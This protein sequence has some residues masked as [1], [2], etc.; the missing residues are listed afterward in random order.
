MVTGASTAELAIVLVDA[1]KGVARADP[2]AR[3]VAALLRVPH[4]VLAVNKMDLGRLRRGHVPRDR[5]RVHRLRR[6]ASASPTSPRS[7][8]RR[9]AGDNVV[10]PRPTR[11]PWYDGPT[12]LE[13]LESVPVG[14]DALSSRSGSPCSWSSVRAPPSTPTTAATPARSPPGWCASA[15]RSP[16]CRRA[17]QHRHRHRHVRRAADRGA[18]A[19]VGDAAARRRRR[20]GARRRA[21]PDRGHDRGRYRPR[22]HGLLAGREAQRPGRPAPGPRR[23]PHG[24]GAAARGRRPARRRHPHGRGVGRR[25]HPARGRRHRHVVGRRRRAR[26]TSTRSAGSRSGWPSRSCSTSTRRTAAPAGS[27]WSTPR[28][29]PRWPPA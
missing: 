26:S 5:R 13:H 7:R 12:L 2:S 25:G 1:R 11:T 4:V 15:T 27:S 23:H 9:C 22:R 19:A 14:R 3:R 24:P 8:C 10:G 21:R 6:A 29:A 20:R 28:T 17:A 18:R 16:C